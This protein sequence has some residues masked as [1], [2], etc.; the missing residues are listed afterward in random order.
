M[1]KNEW[2]DVV[3][4]DSLF[5]GNSPKISSN[6]CLIGDLLYIIGGENELLEIY[7]LDF[8]SLKWGKSSKSISF[9]APIYIFERESCFYVMDHFKMTRFEISKDEIFNETKECDLKNEEFSFCIYNDK[10]YTFGREGVDYVTY[11]YDFKSKSWARKCEI[12]ETLSCHS[13]FTS[14]YDSIVH[15]L[16]DQKKMI[17]V[18]EYDVKNDKHIF[19]DQEPLQNFNMI[20][21]DHFLYFFDLSKKSIP[22]KIRVVSKK[23]EIIKKIKETTS[24]EEIKWRDFVE[25]TIKLKNYK[26]SK[27]FGAGAFGK[28]WMALKK[29]KIVALKEISCDSPNQMNICISEAFNA[30]KLNHPRILKYND[31]FS[32]LDEDEG[33]FKVYIEM[34]LY[35]LGDLSKFIMTYEIDELLLSDFCYQILDGI[36]YIHSNGLIHRDLKPQNILVKLEDDSFYLTICDFGAAKNLESMNVGSFAGTETYVAPEMMKREEIC[37]DRVDIFSFG[38]ILYRFFTGKE[39]R[40]YYDLL[41]N[42]SKVIQEIKNEIQALSLRNQE[43]YLNV[44]LSCLS[45]DP[46]QRPSATELKKLFSKEIK[47]ESSNLKLQEIIE[48]KKSVERPLFEEKKDSDTSDNEK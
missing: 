15:L 27:A 34:E 23:Y 4:D 40:F 22:I 28:I 29:E 46:K 17:R 21:Y 1:K 44:I 43:L 30:M 38:A 33:I 7:I 10:L 6:A 41:E 2:I 19:I 12:K 32:S 9:K 35:P 42:E 13:A 8:S 24:K 48:A 47:L 25:D 37:T 3:L 45:Q 14:G 26:K 18:Y 16:I 11:E 39:R 5:K 20:F 36:E 31:V